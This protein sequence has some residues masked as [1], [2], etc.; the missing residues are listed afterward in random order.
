MPTVRVLLADVE[1][2]DVSAGAGLDRVD[3]ID[4]ANDDDFASS[5][6]ATSV[7]TGTAT[8]QA[9]G[10]DEATLVSQEGGSDVVRLAGASGEDIVKIWPDRWEQDG[11]GYSLGGQGFFQ[12]IATADDAVD[13]AA[14]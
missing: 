12:V 1:Q 9:L 4:S 7:S 14:Q 10:F 6:T 2:A 11:A 8:I 13:V 5:P 3:F